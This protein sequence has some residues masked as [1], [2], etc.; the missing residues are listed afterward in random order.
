MDLS[1]G[2]QEE[3]GEGTYAFVPAEEDGA[4]DAL[5]FT[6]EFKALVQVLHECIALVDRDGFDGIRDVGGF[7]AVDDFE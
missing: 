1:G 4:I 3:E 6:S 2:K 7:G 5:T